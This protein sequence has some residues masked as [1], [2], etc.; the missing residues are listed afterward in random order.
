MIA[1]V[2]AEVARLSD[3]RSTVLVVHYGATSLH[4][5][6]QLPFARVRYAV[7]SAR[8]L[9]FNFERL[10]LRWLTRLRSVTYPNPV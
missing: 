4:S 2:Q 5:S 3:Y 8:S 6:S 9:L 10:K 1:V 7:I